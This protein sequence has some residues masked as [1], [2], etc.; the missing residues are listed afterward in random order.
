MKEFY[1][2]GIVSN[3]KDVV[4]MIAKKKGR[5][6]PFEVNL[7]GSGYFE[8]LKAIIEDSVIRLNKKLCQ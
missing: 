6:I 1:L 4:K 8:A 7:S 3:K 5:G 2:K